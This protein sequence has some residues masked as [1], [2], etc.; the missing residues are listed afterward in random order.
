MTNTSVHPGKILRDEFMAPRNLTP[1]ALAK[2]L[3]MPPARIKAIISD[4]HPWP[5]TCSTAEKL[6]RYF[7]TEKSYWM[8]M[9]SE[10]DDFQGHDQRQTD[11][12]TVEIQSRKY[13][14]DAARLSRSGTG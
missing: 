11:A 6:A 10:F 9:Q 13:S 4:M 3:K 5:I 12:N 2:A 1:E 8:N 14:M 7:G